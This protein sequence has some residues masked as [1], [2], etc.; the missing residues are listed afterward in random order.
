MT[1]NLQSHTLFT[2]LDEA[3]MESITGGVIT[4]LFLDRWAARVIAGTPNLGRISQRLVSEFYRGGLTTAS[5]TN[6]SAG[7]SA[8]NRAAWKTAAPLVSNFLGSGAPIAGLTPAATTA[9]RAYLAL[10]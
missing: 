10:F 5:V 2:D 6:W 8:A 4:S 3:G 9:V 1:T 7:T